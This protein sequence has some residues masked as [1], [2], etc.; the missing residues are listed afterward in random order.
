MANTMTTKDGWT[1]TEIY[2]VNKAK[3]GMVVYKVTPPANTDGDKYFVV[4]SGRYLKY[5]I[6]S[7]TA[8]EMLN[9]LMPQHYECKCDSEL[10]AIT[11]ARNVIYDSIVSMYKYQLGQIEESIKQLRDRTHE[12]IKNLEDNYP[13]ALENFWKSQDTDVE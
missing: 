5:C 4:T 1:Y 11:I 7:H 13:A 8:Q 9:R 10:L 3:P 2:A 6:E 12:M